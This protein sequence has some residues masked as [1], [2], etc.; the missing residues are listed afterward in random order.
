MILFSGQDLQKTI[1]FPKL[2][3]T[4]VKI[5]VDIP[6]DLKAMP[7]LFGLEMGGLVLKS[8]NDQWVKELLISF[9][10]DG[11][12]YDY[13]IKNWDGRDHLIQ[14]MPAL[15]KLDLF[16]GEYRLH[17]IKVGIL[18]ETEKGSDNEIVYDYSFRYDLKMFPVFEAKPGILNEWKIQLPDDLLN[19]LREILAEV[20]NQP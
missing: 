18:S 7:F 4:E 20:S 2:I 11:N 8:A 1:V 16:S 15:E 17:E 3:N 9:A 12:Q 5:Q 6:E 19:Q 10:T 13:Y 14:K